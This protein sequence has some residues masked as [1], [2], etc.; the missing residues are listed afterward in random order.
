MVTGKLERGVIKK[1]DDAIILGHGKTFKTTITGTCH[2]ATTCADV[3]CDS[4]HESGVDSSVAC[5]CV[6]L[7]VLSIHMLSD[8]HNLTVVFCCLVYLA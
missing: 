6:P 2:V 7:V 1:G 3:G 4:G 5:G 8:M